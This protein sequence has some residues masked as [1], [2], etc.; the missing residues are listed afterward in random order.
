VH[1]RYLVSMDGRTQ[2]YG[3]DTLAEYRRFARL[4]PGWRGW[5]DR[6]APDLILWDRRTAFARVLELLPEWRRVYED[7]VAVVYVRRTG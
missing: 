4:E 6:V 3:E 2:V 5:V 7:D 1:D